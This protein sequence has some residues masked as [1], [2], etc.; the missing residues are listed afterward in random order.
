MVHEK[1]FIHHPQKKYLYHHTL[2]HL[3]QGLW[4]LWLSNINKAS[5]PLYSYPKLHISVGVC[6]HH[7]LTRVKEGDS[8]ERKMVDSKE[9]KICTGL[10]SDDGS[11]SDG[12]EEYFAKMLIRPLWYSADEE[13]P[14][15]SRKE[16]RIRTLWESWWFGCNIL[17]SLSFR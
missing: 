4:C 7:F 2:A 10:E 6:W 11:P 15:K 16:K 9:T 1:E 17:S 8:G 12:L 13:L 3:D 14:M 5:M